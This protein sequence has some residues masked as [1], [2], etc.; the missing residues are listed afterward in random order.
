MSAQ[1][2][3]TRGQDDIVA[4]VQGADDM[5]GWAREVL[6]PYLGFDH[7]RPFLNDGVTAEQWAECTEDPAVIRDAAH[8]YYVFA[9]GKIE[10]ERGISAERSVIKLREYAWLMG[11]DDVVAAMDAAQYSPYGAPKVAAFA[12]GLGFSPDGAEVSAPLVVNTVEGAVWTRREAT[13]DGQALYALAGCERCPELAMAT[14]AELAEHGIAGTADALPVPVGPQAQVDPIPLRWGLNDVEW[15][16]DDNV[17]V[18][19]S[20]PNRQPYTLELEPSLAAVLRDVLAGPDGPAAW[21]AAWDTE[22]VGPLYGSEDVARAHCEHDARADYPDGTV[23][24]WRA[25]RDDDA[26]LFTVEAGE[27]RPTGYTVTRQPLASEFVEE[28]SE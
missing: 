6:L 28:A 8:A 2:I 9:L 27:E 24:V 22:Q 17:I 13:R 19:L 15:C 4:R 23:L 5:F 26:K 11:L 3:V 20:G 14:Y 18:L 1:Q 10:D 21:R 16:D 12:A 7:A 25:F